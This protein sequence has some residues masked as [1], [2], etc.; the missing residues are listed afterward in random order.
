MKRHES[1]A[2]VPIPWM[3]WSMVQSMFRC[4]ELVGIEIEGDLGVVAVS[5]SIDYG[6]YNFPY[7]LLGRRLGAPDKL[8]D[9]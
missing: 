1:I 9:W 6:L 3:T 4:G 7:M 2:L 8:I 5:R